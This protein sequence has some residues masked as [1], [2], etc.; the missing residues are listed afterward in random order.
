MKVIEV[1]TPEQL[2]SYIKATNKALDIVFPVEYLK[3]GL[4]RALV[5]AD[6]KVLGGYALIH[7]GNF[8]CIESLPK[9]KKLKVKKVINDNNTLEFNGLWISKEIENGADRLKFWLQLW[10]DISF[11]KK[12]YVVFAYKITNI[13]A[14]R[15]F[16]MVHSQ[17]L[18]RG[19]TDLQPGMTE[20]QYESIEVL[21]V[22]NV[23]RAVVT[24]LN[25]LFR[26]MTDLPLIRYKKVV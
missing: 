20:A 24:K 2:K 9:I 13:N 5:D 10:K 17:T 23:Q 4:V 6:G 15:I 3:R 11:S 18:F 14:E 12:K 26:K 1:K 16:K 21:P 7:K 22:F 8:R 19:V 25:F